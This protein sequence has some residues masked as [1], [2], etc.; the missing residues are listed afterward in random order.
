MIYSSL[1][2]SSILVT[3]STENVTE[4]VDDVQVEE[5]RAD[6]VVVN[7]QL[8]LF[9]LSSNNQLGVISQVEAE[10]NGS[11]H[12]EDQV[13]SW[14]E[15]IREDTSNNEH[16]GEYK[17]DWTA[18][19]QVVLCGGSPECDGDCHCSCHSGCLKHFDW[20]VP[21]TSRGHQKGHTASEDRQQSVV[22]GELLVLPASKQCAESAKVH[23]HNTELKGLVCED[24]DPKLL[25]KHGQSNEGCGEGKL[26]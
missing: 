26:N 3:T 25:R 12:R 10:K 18:D 6:N 8:E 16:Q 20:R 4:N 14:A 13:S 11:E 9:V 2:E 15:G 24:G 22:V 23:E 7:R 19:C 1:L 17:E 5:H 21:G